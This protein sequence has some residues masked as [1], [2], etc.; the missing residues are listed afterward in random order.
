MAGAFAMAQMFS[1]AVKEGTSSVFA[2]TG[3]EFMKSP[4]LGANG[5]IA[6]STLG[7]HRAI[8]YLKRK[9]FGTRPETAKEKDGT[10]VAVYLD[11][12]VGGFAIHLLQK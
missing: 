10:L 1:F 7:I 5:H 11:R 8:A 9:G 3:F 12:E 4:F 2:G 6:V